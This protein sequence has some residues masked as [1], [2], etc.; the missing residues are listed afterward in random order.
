MNLSEID[1]LVMIHVMGNVWPE[2]RCRICGWTLKE[3]TFEGCTAESCSLRPA[4]DRRADEPAYYSSDQGA[5]AR[6]REKLAQKW[7]WMLAQGGEP[8]EKP[9]G[10]ALFAKG[11]PEPSFIDEADTEEL[12]ICRCALQ[13]VGVEIP[14]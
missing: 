12:A 8:G 4:P 7:N 1:R 10:F 6:L 5:A 11:N 9:F 2:D 3:N 13:S 14:E